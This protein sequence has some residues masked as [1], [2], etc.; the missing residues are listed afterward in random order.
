MDFSENINFTCNTTP[1]MGGAK[2]CATVSV[3]MEGNS[4]KRTTFGFNLVWAWNFSIAVGLW[5]ALLST[6]MFIPMTAKGFM[7]GLL[8]IVGLYKIVQRN[9]SAALSWQSSW[10]ERIWMF[11]SVFCLLTVSTQNCVLD[12]NCYQKSCRWKKKSQN[13]RKNVKLS[14]CMRNLSKRISDLLNFVKVICFGFHFC[15]GKRF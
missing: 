2:K 3:R 9:Y 13:L 6:S 7:F 5:M 4:L 14:V 8:K 11:I 12:V 10:K 1:W 15:G